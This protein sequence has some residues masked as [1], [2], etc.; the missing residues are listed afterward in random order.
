MTT[1]GKIVRI[2]PSCVGRFESVDQ[3][4]NGTEVEKSCLWRD[5]CAAFKAY[6]ATMDESIDDFVRVLYVFEYDREGNQVIDD[7]TKKP[8]VREAYGK[9]KMGFQAFVAWSDR[10]AEAFQIK[11]GRPTRVPNPDEIKPVQVDSGHRKFD[12]KVDG[13]KKK[14]YERHPYS[15]VMARKEELMGHFWNFARRLFEMFPASRVPNGNAR[16]AIPGQF[17]I[18]DRR[19]AGNYLT[20]YCRTVLGRDRA[21]VKV[22]LKPQLGTL[23]F[24]LA[25]PFKVV[26]TIVGNVSGRKMGP[27]GAIEDGVFQ[28]EIRGAAKEAGGLVAET[29]FRLSNEGHI[30]LPTVG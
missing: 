15:S 3:E 19:A 6:L 13:K 16:A 28:T 2:V 21:V 11:D 12:R 4:C 17:Y 26:K 10:L 8:K 27:M 14:Q 24:R 23:N 9:A 20:I 30:D 25:V 7:T 1:R 29:I 22:I 18:I 5:R